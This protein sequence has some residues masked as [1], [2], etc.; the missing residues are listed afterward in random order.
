MGFV[1]VIFFLIINSN[2]SVHSK[3]EKFHE[4]EKWLDST[5][6]RTDLPHWG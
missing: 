3:T 2:L 6:L 4:Y 1:V 5:N